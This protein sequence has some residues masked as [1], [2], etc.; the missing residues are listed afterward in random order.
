MKRCAQ[1]GSEY[2]Q[3]FNNCPSCGYSSSKVDHYFDHKKEKVVTK[4]VYGPKFI[5]LPPVVIYIIFVIAFAIIGYVGYTSYMLSKISLPG[6]KSDN[7]SN[8]CID[9]CEGEFIID[10]G[11]CICLDE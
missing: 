6:S 7:D 9:L 2:N 1:C 4:D 3:N 10:D 11:N 5:E 8:M